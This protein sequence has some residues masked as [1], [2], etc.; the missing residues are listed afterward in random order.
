MEGEGTVDNVNP[1]NPTNDAAAIMGMGGY[2]GTDFA[3]TGN[4]I[5][6]KVLGQIFGATGLSFID[7]LAGI[8]IGNGIAGRG[9]SNDPTDQG[10]SGPQDIADII[11]TII[12]GND[13][14]TRRAITPNPGAKQEG[15]RR[16]G[17]GTGSNIR[18]PNIGGGLRRRPSMRTVPPPAMM[19]RKPGWDNPP[20]GL[21]RMPRVIDDKMLRI[22][23]APTGS[24]TSMMGTEQPD[25]SKMFADVLRS[26]EQAVQDRSGGMQYSLGKLLNRGDIA[27]DPNSINTATAPMMKQARAT[28]LASMLGGSRVPNNIFDLTNLG[29]NIG[30][31]QGAQ[32]VNVRG[33]IRPQTRRY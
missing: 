8:N 4:P 13:E 10:A 26:S 3:P 11:R 22:P 12:G 9:S 32:N 2:G 1:G 21:E 33:R 31:Q 30:T 7:T 28:A 16:F 6:D 29:A 5:V 17:S 14:G 27:A 20:P 25:L 23:I 15:S 24:V 18:Y 19:D